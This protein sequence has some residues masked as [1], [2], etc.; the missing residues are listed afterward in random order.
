MGTN[1]KDI[2]F[3]LDPAVF[4]EGRSRTPKRSRWLYAKVKTM[5][6]SGRPIEIY[7]FLKP[8]N[9]VE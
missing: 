7:K 9:I 6:G 1:D 5:D 8:Y 3:V 2:V 4:I